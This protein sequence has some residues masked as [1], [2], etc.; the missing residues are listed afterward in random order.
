[1]AR[2]RSSKSPRKKKSALPQLHLPKLKGKEFG[3]RLLNLATHLVPLLWLLYFVHP[4]AIAGSY[5]KWDGNNPISYSKF[6]QALF[7]AGYLVGLILLH[8]PK[9]KETGHLLLGKS[10]LINGVWTLHAAYVQKSGTFSF[11]TGYIHLIFIQL[12]VHH[13]NHVNWLKKDKGCAVFF[14]YAKHAT[15]ILYWVPATYGLLK[16]SPGALSTLQNYHPMFTIARLVPFNT[17]RVLFAMSYTYLLSVFLIIHKSSGKIKKFATNYKLII[18]VFGVINL[19]RWTAAE[20]HYTT[21]GHLF[22][23][24]TM[25]V[26]YLCDLG[27]HLYAHY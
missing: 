5:K 24:T 18:K 20:G 9:S 26:V 10:F 15:D 22:F 11:V 3:S 25:I 27:E 17:S 13:L 4:S 7:V 21:L 16:L 14:H 12:G 23:A 6:M 19:L 1:M 8:R 2:R